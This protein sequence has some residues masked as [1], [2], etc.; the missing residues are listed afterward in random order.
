MFW[1]FSFQLLFLSYVTD[2]R[3]KHDSCMDDK[4]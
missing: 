4:E 2:K 3:L 1:Q